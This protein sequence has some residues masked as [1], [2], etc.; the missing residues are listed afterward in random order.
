MLHEIGDKVAFRRAVA[1]EP[2]AEVSVILV[3]RIKHT[4]EE[5]KCHYVQV[6]E[7]TVCCDH[8]VP[9]WELM[10][11]QDIAKEHPY[12]KQIARAR[13]RL[14]AMPARERSWLVLQGSE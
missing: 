11:V 14:D 13:A 1:G 10:S 8:F 7:D 6:G 2:G 9:D 4:D 5:Q 3:G 12:T